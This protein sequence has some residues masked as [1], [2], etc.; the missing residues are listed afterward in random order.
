MRDA[1]KRV[2]LGAGLAM[3]LPRLLWFGLCAAI[4]GR[5]RAFEGA[6]QG[7]A[8]VP[9]LRGVLMRRAFLTVALADCHHTVTVSYGVLMSK[10]GASL[11]E[12]VYVGPGCSLGLVSL[13]K[14][15]LLADGVRIPSGGHTHASTDASV[16][17]REQG[18]TPTRVRVGR[19]TWV[20]SGA[21][22]LADVGANC[23]IG[24]GA[25]VTRP[26]P[27]NVVAVGVPAKAIRA[28]A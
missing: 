7:L 12:N 23:V 26:I 13:E 8:R 5:D 21:V 3:V 25:V 9:G 15:V 20:G 4:L 10:A 17:I 18:G 16:P 24:A 19:G 1:L 14:D 27:D 28:R 11:G 22:I 6:V 2:A